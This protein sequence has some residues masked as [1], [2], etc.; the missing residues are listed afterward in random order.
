M[1]LAEKGQEQFRDH[2]HRLHPQ[3]SAAQAL[4]ARYDSL[5]AALTQFVKADPE[6]YLE[7]QT[8]FLHAA[9]RLVIGTPGLLERVLKANRSEA[10]ELNKATVSTIYRL[11]QEFL[12]EVKRCAGEL[13][14]EAEQES[15]DADDERAE[16]FRSDMVDE[17]L[18]KQQALR[19]QSE[20]K[21]GLALA[22]QM[23]GARA[24]ATWEGL[25]K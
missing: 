2:R 4:A 14:E 7:A 12:E 11:M 25:L 22:T 3:R 23:F 13:T 6:F 1:Q 24:G 9:K 16:S 18:T 15:Q 5:D 17:L 20:G 21:F 10:I 19:Q 8:W